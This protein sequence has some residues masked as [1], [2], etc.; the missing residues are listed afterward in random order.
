MRHPLDDGQKL[1]R[2]F[3]I[4]PAN[5]VELCSLAREADPAF[6]TIYKRPIVSLIKMAEMYTDKTLDKGKVRTS[7]WEARL[8]E[9]QKT[10]ESETPFALPHCANMRDNFKDAANDA[11]VALTVYLRLIAIAAQHN[12]ALVPANYTSNVTGQ[13]AAKQTTVLAPPLATPTTSVSSSSTNSE[14]TST[15]PAP[16]MRPLS[17]VT[18]IYEHS[19]PKPQEMRAYNLWHHEKM[20]LSDICATLRSKDHPLAKSTVM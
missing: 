11:H 12:R 10:C 6:I 4:L 9:L 17:Y 1:F 14:H 19:A 16:S 7:N 5:L 2:D 13:P 18:S 3:G 15:R 8:T 20:P